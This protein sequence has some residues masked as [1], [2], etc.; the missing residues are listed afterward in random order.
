LPFEIFLTVT[1][2]QNLTDYKE[3]PYL[4]R[5]Y[6]ISYNY[7]ATLWKENVNAKN[8]NNN[9]KLLACASDYT[10]V[11]SVQLFNLRDFNQAN[12]RTHLKPLPAAK[13]E[14]T[15]L[16][17]LFQGEFLSGNA[18]TE[19]Y[20]KANANKYSILHLAMHGILNNSLPILSSLA[21][22]ENLDTVEDNY[23][24]A[25]EISHLH[26]NADLVVLSACETGYGQFKQGEGV[27]S[28]AR[29]FM[30]AG[31]PSLVVSLWQVNDHSTAIIM[32]YFYNYLS[33][34]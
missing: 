10:P 2:S 23:L 9:G 24:Q 4:I 8:K 3:L 29:S 16:S 22:T 33:M 19:S 17:D 32:Q 25:Y 15:A 30:Y 7:S 11:D 14:I 5:D 21:F 18:T 27:M 12:L 1:P 31:V 13:E 26:L 20:F 34:A 6:T 28:L